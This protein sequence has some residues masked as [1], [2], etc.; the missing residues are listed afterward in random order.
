MNMKGKGNMKR[1]IAI[2][3]LL[4]MTAAPAVASDW[5]TSAWGGVSSWDCTSNDC[6]VEAGTERYEAVGL[7]VGRSI[8]RGIFNLRAELAADYRRHQIHGLNGTDCRNFGL[9]V[10]RA[11]SYEQRYEPDLKC[12]VEKDLYV[13][14]LGVNAWPGVDVWRDVLGIYAGG[15]FGVMLACGI[16]H[17]DTAPSYMLG[18]G[19]DITVTERLIV[20]IGYRAI[21]AIGDMELDGQELR[22][23]RSR[24][25]T[26]GVR[27]AF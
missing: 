10:A 9:G 26:V 18:G 15:G 3:F 2:V 13:G 4:V 27:W 19:F 14:T 6:E 5:Y 23:Y 17:C 7:A 16:G 21:F 11:S 1:Y 25:P 22:D 20:D 24:G 8:D 12:E